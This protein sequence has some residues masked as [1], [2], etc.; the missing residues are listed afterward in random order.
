MKFR[1]NN[2]AAEN[3]VIQS[4]LGDTS[5][6]RIGGEL[7]FPF[8]LFKDDPKSINY[9]SVRAGYRYEQSPYR[10]TIAT[11]G[12]LKG[13][14]MGVGVTLGGVRIDASYDIAK[15]TNTF[16]LYES[17]LTDKATLETQ[18]NNFAVTLTWTLF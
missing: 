17:I 9:F 15:Q 8:L 16:A 2:L 11:V 5:T 1:S 6:L 3:A 18:N 14:A 7:R 12:D 4:E 13:Y 10:R